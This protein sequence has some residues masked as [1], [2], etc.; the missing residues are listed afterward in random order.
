MG[1]KMTWEEVRQLY[2]ATFVLLTDCDE[3][4]IGADKVRITKG[5][6]VFVNPNGKLIYDEYCKYGQ[7][8]HMTFGH[9]SW[10]TLDLEEAPFLGIRPAHE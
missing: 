6:V 2:P 3:E 8:P 1:Q 9:T 7:P 10:S 4:H 5:T